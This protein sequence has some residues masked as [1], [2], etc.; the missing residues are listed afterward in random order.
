MV[1]KSHSD[2][3]EIRTCPWARYKASHGHS[4]LSCLCLDLIPWDGVVG[5]GEGESVSLGYMAVGI[6]Y[7]QLM[8][9]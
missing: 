5:G 9:V 6:C 4:A 7:S 1:K 3:D 2:K 8:I